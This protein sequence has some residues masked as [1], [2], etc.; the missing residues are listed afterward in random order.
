MAMCLRTRSHT[1]TS[2]CCSSTTSIG[3][4]RTIYRRNWPRSKPSLIMK[5]HQKPSFPGVVRTQSSQPNLLQIAL[6]VHLRSN[7]RCRSDLR[8]RGL[9]ETCHK[10]QLS[11]S[12]H[13]NTSRPRRIKRK[14][15][16][17]IIKARAPFQVMVVKFR[18]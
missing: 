17:S 8:C 11:S 6:S 14:L 12:T 4:I 1:S 5:H 3:K 13:H 15:H 10:F 2:D 16:I 7:S 9:G 18:K